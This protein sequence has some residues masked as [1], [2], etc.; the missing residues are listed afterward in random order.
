MQNK[1]NRVFFGAALMAE[2]GEKIK[3]LKWV[4]LTHDNKLLAKNTL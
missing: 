4:D 1:Y 3:A 2:S